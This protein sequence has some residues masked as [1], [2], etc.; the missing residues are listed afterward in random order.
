MLTGDNTI[1][2]R[3]VPTEVGIDEVIAEARRTR[4]PAFWVARSER[5]VML[6][7]RCSDGAR[8]FRTEPAR[9][10]RFRHANDSGRAAAPK[11]RALIASHCPD[12]PI[13]KPSVSDGGLVKRHYL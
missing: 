9:P 12:Q 3:T 11:C 2:A 10:A 1:V 4:W 13:Q 7:S 5:P 8:M 6:I